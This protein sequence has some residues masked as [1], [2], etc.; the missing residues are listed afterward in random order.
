MSSMVRHPMVTLS[1]GTQVPMTSFGTS[2]L[3]P[4]E[5]RP[6]IAAAVAAGYRLVDTA[7]SY[8]NEISVGE[9]IQA[10]PEA[11]EVMVS[12]KIRGPAHGYDS[13]IRAAHESMERL[14]RQHLDVLLIHWPLPTVDRYV[15]TWR[16]LQTLRDEGLV[17]TIGVS[18]FLP[19][20]LQ[21]LY[22]ETGEWP[23]LNQIECHLQNWR[24]EEVAFHASTG[25]RTQAWSPL[26]KGG[27]VLE[28]EAVLAAAR[29]TGRT[30]GQVVL[31][32]HVQRGVLPVPKSATPSRI[33]ENAAITDFE[34]TD[35]EMTSFEVLDVGIWLGPDPRTH[36][37]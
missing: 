2:Q 36:V 12:T 22:E 7:A 23:A 20:H 35:S 5:V 3:R 15:D 17:S 34:L 11:D 6:A 30:P 33:A 25:I 18:N 32:W 4:D 9:A 28:H 8:C 13:T 31:R 29:R 26:A 1:S 24:R 19:E 21:R 37:E 27:D 14:Q 10:L 16:A